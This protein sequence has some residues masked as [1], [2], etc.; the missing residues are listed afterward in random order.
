[1]QINKCTIDLE[2]IRTEKPDGKYVVG[3]GADNGNDLEGLPPCG[4]TV[5]VYDEVIHYEEQV[6]D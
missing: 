4:Q 1:V 3:Q 2:K 6:Q 5:W